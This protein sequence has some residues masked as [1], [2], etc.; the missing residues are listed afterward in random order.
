MFASVHGRPEDETV[1][2][3]LSE[4]SHSTSSQSDARD[5]L[6][7]MSIETLRKWLVANIVQLALAHGKPVDEIA[8][9]L[10]SQSEPSA[11]SQSDITNEST[12]IETLRKWLVE[13]VGKLASAHG[14]PLDDIV[15]ASLTVSG[16]PQSKPT[17]TKDQRRSTLVSLFGQKLGKLAT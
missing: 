10:L 16:N 1:K 11:S 6:S 14:K 17:T 4:S 15:K 3:L 9:A 12:A 2:A 8:K 13:N 7:S 5:P